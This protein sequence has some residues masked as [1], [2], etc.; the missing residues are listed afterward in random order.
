MARDAV[1]NLFVDENGQPFILTD[2]QCAIF[3]LIYQRRVPRVHLMTY[4]QYGKTHTVA[5]A[6]LLRAAVFP[7]KWCIVAGREKQAK[8]CMGYVIQHAFDNEYTR[9]RLVVPK[10]EEDKLKREKSKNRLTF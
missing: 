2:M 4:T 5:L 8:I 1:R 9:S 7:E 3:L 10:G 6:V